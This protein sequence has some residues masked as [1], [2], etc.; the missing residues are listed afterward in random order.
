MQNVHGRLRRHIPSSAL[1]AWGRARDTQ[2]HEKNRTSGSAA[3]PAN[4]IR[5]NEQ[6][7]EDRTW[8]NPPLAYDGASDAGVGAESEATATLRQCGDLLLRGQWNHRGAL[9]H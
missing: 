7:S 9:R 4:R 5:K 6:L 2:S 3:I 8:G 1:L